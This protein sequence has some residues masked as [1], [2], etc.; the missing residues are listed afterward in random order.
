M[1]NAGLASTATAANR[2]AR[3]LYIGGLGGVAETEVMAFFNETVSRVWRAG[4]H[5]VGAY[6]N[7]QNRFAFVE[8]K[9]VKGARCGAN[10]GE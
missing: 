3:R 10:D 9:D 8:F 1:A 7:N 2:P 6:V 4:D 5:I